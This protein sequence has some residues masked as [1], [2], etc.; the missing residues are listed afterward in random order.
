MAVSVAEDGVTAI[1]AGDGI[2]GSVGLSLPQAVQTSSESTE[3]N[4]VRGI[5]RSDGIL[6]LLHKTAKGRF[7]G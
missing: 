1:R 6:C 2:A 5:V 3:R 7:I 4:M